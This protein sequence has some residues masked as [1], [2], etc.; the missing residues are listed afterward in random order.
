MEEPEV[1]LERLGRAAG[2]S[3]LQ[4][5]RCSQAEEDIRGTGPGQ[6]GRATTT[7]LSTAIK[8]GGGVTVLL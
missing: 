3:Q 8:A 6:S 4:E 7:A 2:I 5:K 1:I